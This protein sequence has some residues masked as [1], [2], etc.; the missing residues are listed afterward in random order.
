MPLWVIVEVLNDD[1][2]AAGV[3]K[4]AHLGVPDKVTPAITVE[5]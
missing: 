2:A 4:Q 1:D 3:C 5:T